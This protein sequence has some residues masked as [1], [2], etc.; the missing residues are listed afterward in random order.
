MSIR[1]EMPVLA[2]H[3]GE[4]IGTYIYVDAEGGIVDR[5]TSHLTCAFP[6]DGEADYLQINR[7]AWES[8]RAEEHRFPAIF[9]DGSLWLDSE[10]LKGRAWEVDEKTIIMT[11][12]YKADLE[13]YLY[14][15]IQISSDGADRARTWHW[16]EHGELV[17]RTLIKEKRF[18]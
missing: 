15:M 8:G 2:R 11:W 9:R 3:E 13:R 5:H 6:A 4:W 10:R 7:Y 16:F 17:K 1:E 18:N 14:E 12:R